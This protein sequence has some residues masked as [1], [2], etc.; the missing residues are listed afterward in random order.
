[1]CKNRKKSATFYRISAILSVVSDNNQSSRIT[2]LIAGFG[3][4]FFYDILFLDF[5]HNYYN[6]IFPGKEI[7][8]YFDMCRILFNPF[9]ENQNRPR[10]LPP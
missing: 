4:I 2:G 3:D 9:S 10:F 7:L 5:M 1:M 8:S 6:V